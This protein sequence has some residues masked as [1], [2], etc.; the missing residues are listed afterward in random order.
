MTVKLGDR[1]YYRDA[2]PEDT[3]TIVDIV[4]HQYPFVVKW[5]KQLPSEYRT[6]MFPP[7]EFASQ[8]QVKQVEIFANSADENIDQFC[9][10]QLI[11]LNEDL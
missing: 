7:K 9:A 11:L 10:A 6:I 4:F 1:V 3:G 5:D 8:L 2:G